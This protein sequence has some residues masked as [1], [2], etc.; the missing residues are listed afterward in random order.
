MIFWQAFR[1]IWNQIFKQASLAGPK[2]QAGVRKLRR[3]QEQ[4]GRAESRGAWC[5]A[6]PARDAAGA[7]RG[8]SR[9]RLAGAQWVWGAAGPGRG[10]CRCGPCGVRPVRVLLRLSPDYAF[11]PK[12]HRGRGNNSLLRGTSWSFIPHPQVWRNQMFPI[13]TLFFCPVNL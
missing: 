9:V 1:L 10:Q 11:V 6:R 5:G 8:R 2:T 4:S 7:G 12:V 3:Q 13:K